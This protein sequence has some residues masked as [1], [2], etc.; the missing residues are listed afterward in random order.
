[1]TELL[2]PEFKPYPKIARL[3][4][5]IL[6]TEKIDGTNAIIHV[7]EDPTGP[8]LAGSRTRWLTP[9]SKDNFGFAAWVALHAEALRVLGPGYHYGEWWGAGIQRRYGLTEK[10]FSLFAV[11][12]WGDGR[13]P[14]PACCGVVPALWRGGWEGVELALERLRAAGSVAA[15]G[16][17]SPEGIVV[18]HRASG[19]LWKVTLQG[20]EQAKGAT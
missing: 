19:G 15:P 11:D 20:D 8:V 3:R 6:I 18:F 1:M 14:R 4:R 9:N 16:W 10:R 12:R 5:E 13:Q 17:P 7:P 2:L